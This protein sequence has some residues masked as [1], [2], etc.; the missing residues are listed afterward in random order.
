M[1]VSN[2]EFGALLATLGAAPSIEDAALTALA[3]L[4]AE[5]L[6]RVCALPLAADHADLGTHAACDPPRRFETPPPATLTDLSA[7]LTAYDANR[8]RSRQVAIGPSEIGVPCD[9]RLAYSLVNAPPQPWPGVKWAPLLGTAVHALIADALR[10]ANDRAGRVRWLVEQ[11]VVADRQVDGSCDAYDTDTDTVI[12]WKLVGKS[13]A[14][15]ARRGGPGDQY[16]AQAHIYGRGWQRIGRD[17]RWVRIVFLPRWSSSITD[18][19]EWTA[20]Y[21]RLSAERALTRRSDVAARAAALDLVNNPADWA[22]IPGAVSSGDCYFCPYHRASRNVIDLDGC[23][24]PRS[25]PA[26]AVDDYLASL[27][28]AARIS[29]I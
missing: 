22:R 14:D 2:A 19:Y 25:K 4:G 28:Q 12:D 6:C 16:E 9:R 18:A 29:G 5:L 21:S 15:K 26:Q 20:P 17:P 1:S 24:G 3:P 23:S 11:R 7:A 27:P 10:D 8:A 13:T